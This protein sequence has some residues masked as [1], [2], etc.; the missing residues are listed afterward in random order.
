MKKLVYLA[1]LSLAAALFV[2]ACGTQEAASVPTA[3][4]QP[5]AQPAASPPD[6]TAQST[7]EPTAAQTAPTATSVPVATAAPTEAAS[8]TPGATETATTT[9]SQGEAVFQI[10]TPD[11]QTKGLSLSDLKKLPQATITVEGKSENGPALLEVLRSAGVTEFRQVTLTGQGGGRITLSKN[12]VTPDVVLDF[13]ERGTMKLASPAV[14][15]K[16]GSRIS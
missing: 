9:P 14:P 7:I 2:G 15:K 8:P 11:G 3:T 12:Q 16:D 13:T 10:V 6:S 4:A 1:G 5:T